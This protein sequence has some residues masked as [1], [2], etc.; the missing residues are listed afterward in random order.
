M[1]CGSESQES[2]QTESWTDKHLKI[3][4]AHKHSKQ[5]YF[6]PC[7]ITDPVNTVSL[8]L[9]RVMFQHGNKQGVENIRAWDS[10]SQLY[11]W[12]QPCTPLSH[13]SGHLF[14]THCGTIWSSWTS[15]SR[16]LCSHQ[17]QQVWCW[18]LSQQNT[19]TTLMRYP[20]SCSMPPKPSG[21]GVDASDQQNVSLSFLILG[22]FF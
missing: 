3:R 22:F 14:L 12:N 8:Q 18:V 19:T 1:R 17:Q 5:S 15:S 11:H 2:W 13:W 7:S 6:K 16:L 10:L 21:N 20:C 4:K 9:K